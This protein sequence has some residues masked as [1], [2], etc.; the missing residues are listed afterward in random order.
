MAEGAI[1]HGYRADF[2][3]MELFKLKKCVKIA[4]PMV[5]SLLSMLRTH[6]L[7]EFTRTFL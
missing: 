2:D 3:V 7:S 4:A 6:N 5:Q 1:G